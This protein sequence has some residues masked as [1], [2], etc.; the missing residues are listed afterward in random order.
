MRIR[1]LTGISGLDFNLV[2]REE[3]ERFT[4]GEALRLMLSDQAEPADE[5]SALAL[6]A[7]CGGSQIED[8]ADQA[9]EGQDGA[10]EPEAA[11]GEAGDA[12][13][14]DHADEGQEG[15]QEPEAAA[16]EAGAADQADE[17]DAI[18]NA[19][20]LKSIARG[21]Q[22]DVGDAR[23]AIDLRA[24]IRAGRKAKVAA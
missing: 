17:L 13:A 8:A 4:D 18:S 11:A 2:P 20:K 6:A 3:T 14:A 15:A 1:M 9:D 16:G 22:I 10:Q 7:A 24:A 23:S 12:G 21:E 5:E 19:L